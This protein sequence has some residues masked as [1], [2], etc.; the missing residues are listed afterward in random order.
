MLLTEK[1]YETHLSYNERDVIKFIE[2]EK[3][4]IENYSTTYI[5]DKT[6]TT[7]STLVRI[8]KKLGYSGW[9][10]FKKDYLKEIRYLNSHF[11]NID[12]NTPFDEDDSF[13]HIAIRLDNYIRKV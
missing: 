5:A 4:K 2:E 12:A 1:I 10:D 9:N 8:A 13:I 11:N 6:D 7:P 3:E